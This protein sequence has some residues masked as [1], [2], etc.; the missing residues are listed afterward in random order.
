MAYRPGRADRRNVGE[1]A[2]SPAADALGVGDAEI[3]FVFATAGA[4]RASDT[5]YRAAR[6][7]GKNLSVSTRVAPWI[8]DAGPMC[9]RHEPLVL[10]ADDH[11]DTCEIHASYLGSVG[12]QPLILVVDDD[13]GV[14]GMIAVA[15][16]QLNY[17]ARVAL[18]AADAL[19]LAEMQRPDAIL[20]D[21]V[22]PDSSG[23]TTLDRLRELR[24]GVP[25]IMITAN[26]DD[27]LALETL[28]HGAFDYLMKPFDLDLLASVVVA[29]LAS[30]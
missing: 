5:T 16:S 11:R 19:A 29:A 30:R 21:I 3:V 28:R 12:Y 10:I 7:D 4:R 17:D 14:A 15:L 26:D 2:A 6:S 20:L 25:I 18:T 24:P 1:A 9:N 23:T 27:E 13:V 8:Y 22:L